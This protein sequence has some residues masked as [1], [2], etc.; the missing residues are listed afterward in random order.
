MRAGSH[1][2]AWRRAQIARAGVPYASRNVLEDPELRQG[3]K[4]FTAWPT[5]PQVFIGGQFVVRGSALGG[6]ER[7][8]LP[9]HDACGAHRAGRTF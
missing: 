1:V 2:V 7:R 6:S 9:S 3:I 8:R 4:S 5:I